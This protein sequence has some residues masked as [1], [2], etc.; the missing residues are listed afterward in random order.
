MTVL[1]MG[2]SGGSRT[3]A[4]GRPLPP[5]LA[6]GLVFFA[7]GAVLVIEVVGL[8]LVAP[9]MASPCRRAAP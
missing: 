9:Y 5:R 2:V 3:E 7:S 8:R 1:P 6:A 4:E